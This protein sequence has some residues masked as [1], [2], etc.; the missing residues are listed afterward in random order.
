MYLNKPLKPRNGQLLMLAILARISGCTNQK[1]ASLDDQEDHGR[2]EVSGHYSGPIETIVIKTKAKGERFD[3]PELEE[4]R[5]LIRSRKID[6]LFVEDL[7]RMIRGY[8]ALEILYMA[9]DHGVRVLSPNDGIDTF[10]DG[11]EERAGA[12]SNEH[13][14]ANVQTS[15]RIKHKTM[16]RFKRE[17][18]VSKRP[19]AGYEVPVGAKTYTEWTKVD[20]L[21]PIIQD[22][23]TFML[24]K[25]NW[26][27][28]A[29]WLN[30]RNFPVSKYA[31]R[32]VYKGA[33]ARRYITNTLLKGMPRRGYMHSI[34]VGANGARKSVKNP[35]GPTYYSAPHLAHVTPEVFDELQAVMNEQNEGKGPPV[36]EHPLKGVSRKRSRFPGRCARCWYC[37]SE[38]VWGGN[39]IPGHLMCNGARNRT[40]WS[41]MGFSAAIA[42]NAVLK[43]L[44]DELFGLAAFEVQFSALIAQAATS[45]RSADDALAA[46]LD[47]DARAL[48]RERENILAAIRQAGPHE[49]LNEDLDRIKKQEAQLARDRQKLDLARETAP[50]VPATTA[51]LKAEFDKAFQGLAK[52]SYD[53]ADTLRN[54]VMEFHVFLVRLV[55]GGHPLPRARVVL[56]LDGIVPDLAR[57]PEMAGFLRRELIIDLFEP[58]QRARI[59]E[60]VVKLRQDG[61]T[62]N[63][64]M[65][66]I[67]EK[68]T[69]TV[70]QQAMAL[71]RTIEQQ[72]LSSPYMMLDAPPDDYAK[73]RRH[74]HRLY[75][76]TPVAGYQ[77]PPLA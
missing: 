15:R 2:E 64:I 20:A 47:A 24:A 77:R 8:A 66:R 1:E 45:V 9:H 71:H 58:P 70:V 3:R 28:L 34:K 63:Q 50:D 30:E 76:F 25:K 32:K 17:G 5:Q 37:G 22:A 61:M 68:P 4:V 74:K 49:M 14:T 13:L 27:A 44:K 16:N 23:F 72:G 53:F 26:S 46:K 75:K 55:D 67:A 69:K 10:E 35:D 42:T 21:T 11:W 7:G 18:K 29:E 31:K 54:L 12:A 6:V 59:R 51:G 73:L 60:Q 39:G 36:T 56:A 38:L 65:E 43:V 57:I 62:E 48:A 41:S 19:I 33:S 40:C 52:D